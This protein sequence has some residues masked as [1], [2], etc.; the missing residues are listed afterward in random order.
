MLLLYGTNGI[1]Q[2]DPTASFDAVHKEGVA[3]FVKQ[4][5][6]VAQERLWGVYPNEK[7]E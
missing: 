1:S 7:V 6:F 5:G 4:Q 3:T 2:G